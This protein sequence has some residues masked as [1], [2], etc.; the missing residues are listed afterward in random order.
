M[1]DNYDTMTIT[2]RMNKFILVHNIME[3]HIQ[4]EFRNKLLKLIKES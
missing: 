1:Y 3:K 4:N 2:E